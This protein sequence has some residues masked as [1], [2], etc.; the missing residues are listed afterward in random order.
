MN[1]ILLHEICRFI[2]QRNGMK[3]QVYEPVINC[4]FS[5]LDSP[6][7]KLEKLIDTKLDILQDIG[8]FSKA[9][10]V[11]CIL[12]RLYSTTDCIVCLN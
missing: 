10:T 2:A 5:D 4:L 11:P 9:D 7:E 1:P 6:L 3:R 8:M 12:Y